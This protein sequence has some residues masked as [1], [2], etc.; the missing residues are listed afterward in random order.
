MVIMISAPPAA[1]SSRRRGHASARFSVPKPE[2]I[3]TAGMAA[4]SSAVAMGAGPAAGGRVRALIAD[5]SEASRQRLRAILTS[6]PGV[7]VIAECSDGLQ[8]VDAIARLR[9]DAAFLDVGLPGLDGFAV[10]ARLGELRPHV[11]FVSSSREDAAR[12]FELPALDYV[13]KPF[14]DYRLL[15]A[16]ERVFRAQAARPSMPA[17]ELRMLLREIRGGR[18]EHLPVRCR[19][20]TLLLPLD[21]INWIEAQNS[22]VR[23]HHGGQ[24]HSMRATLTELE[25][26]LPGDRFM[27][28]HREAIV[29]LARVEEVMPWLSGDFRLVLYDRSVVPLGRRYRKDFEERLLV[30]RLKAAP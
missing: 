3:R 11:V 30:E 28:V 13:L 10:C 21:E 19:R 9:P 15:A 29:N 8:A 7:A 23:I 5:G 27:R 14:D 12:A 20:A 16:V 22:S 1:A 6:R 2:D 17:D 26:R 25:G 18:V 24:A 4:A